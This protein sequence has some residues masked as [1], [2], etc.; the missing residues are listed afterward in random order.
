MFRPT[1]RVLLALV[2]VGFS[3]LGLT[4]RNGVDAETSSASTRSHRSRASIHWREAQSC[5]VACGYMLARLL[6]RDIVYNNA[7][8][9]IPVENGGTSLL[10]MQ[11]GLRG[12]G[13]ST[14][15]LRAKPT[16]LD[17]IAMPVIAHMLPRRE[18]GSAVGHF[19]LVLQIDERSVQYIEPNYAA[20]IETVPRTQFLRCWTGYLVAPTARRTIAS[21]CFDVGLW[22]ALAA[23]ISLGSVTVVRSTFARVRPAWL[24]PRLLFFL[25]VV[26]LCCLTSGCTRTSASL[27]P[28]V[29]EPK[30]GSRL[31]AWNTE[32]DLG[33]L[34]PA[35]AAEASFRIEN[36]GTTAAH[37]HLGTPT[38]RCTRARLEA[39]E[40]KPGE[41]TNVHLVMESRAHQAGP[42]D[43]RVYVEAEEGR[44]AELL[45]VHAMQLGANFPDYSYAIGGP[46][47]ESKGASVVGNLFLRSATVSP[48]VELSLAGTGVESALAIRDLRLGPPIEAGGGIRRE[49]SFVVELNS[50]ATLI[51]ERKEIALPVSVNIEGQTSV[52]HV[53]VIILPTNNSK[54]T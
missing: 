45:S 50:T 10:D 24:R 37:L 27:A 43:A 34:P 13:V 26:W 25:N 32:A 44:W 38:C 16:E 17:R 6:G 40:L 21:L 12:L 49:C 19:L 31:V 14:S 53:R 28:R 48:R 52:Q 20:S 23:S 54:A 47:A 30:D 1:S 9:A 29:D 46:P 39:Q 5:G 42:A 41:S 7:V 15:I 2:V 35:G 11:R 22:A 4:A 8:E 36:Q 33:V 18:A 51:P 3:I